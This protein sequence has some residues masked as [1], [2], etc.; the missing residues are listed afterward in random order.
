[1]IA[2][3]PWK[4]KLGLRE[5]VGPQRAA[6]LLR[7]I[8]CVIYMD[9][10]PSQSLGLFDILGKV[11]KEEDARAPHANFALKGLIDRSIRF[12][13]S[14]Q[15]TRVT[16]LEQTRRWIVRLSSIALG[17][18]S[19]PVRFVGVAQKRGL[20]ILA[21]T[22]ALNHIL[23]SGVLIKQPRIVNPYEFVVGVKVVVGRS[24]GWEKLFL[25]D[26]PALKILR[27]LSADLH[28]LGCIKRFA[29]LN[30][31]PHGQPRRGTPFAPT[32]AV[33]EYDPAPIKADQLNL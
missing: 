21:R 11:I 33:L 23:D 8:A 32:A 18:M 24:E 22:Q 9:T 31:L 4:T 2:M 30:W 28:V 27:E 15:V 14:Q 16:V 29:V 26:Q 3:N 25:R 5:A 12:G 17:D 10:G 20:D 19:R 7:S 6:Y 1:M 13:E